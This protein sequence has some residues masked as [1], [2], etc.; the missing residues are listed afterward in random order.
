[1]G[2][3]FHVAGQ[4]VV[5]ADDLMTFFE[6]IIAQMASEKARPAGD[7]CPSIELCSNLPID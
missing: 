5:D 2:D 1:V 7:Q 6:Q 3:V 4:E